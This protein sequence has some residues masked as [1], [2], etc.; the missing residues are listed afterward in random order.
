MPEQCTSK[1]DPMLEQH[2]SEEDPM[3]V[4]T[5]DLLGGGYDCEIVESP[6]VGL[7][8]ECHVCLQILRE[9][10]MVT[11]CCKRFCHSCINRIQAAGKSCPLCNAITYDVVH[12]KKLEQD[13]EGRKVY[14]MH[15]KSG[16]Q[17]TG[18]LRQYEE[19]LNVNP[20]S[21]TQLEGCGFVKI[22]CTHCGSLCQRNLT[23]SHRREEC[24]KWRTH[25]GM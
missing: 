5:K 11:C 24:Q 14:C 18:E 8:T 16:C 9:P 19:H 25:R 23:T 13:L 17:W 3:P 21:E 7:Q 2:S 6:T 22:K 15:A 10:H 4:L 12:D 20:E 1:K